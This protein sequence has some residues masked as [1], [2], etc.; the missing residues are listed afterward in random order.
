M[1]EG[2]LDYNVYVHPAKFVALKQIDCVVCKLLGLYD[3]PTSYSFVASLSVI[4]EQFL[5][6]VQSELAVPTQGEQ[7][8]PPFPQ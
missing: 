4:L 7:T 8:L 6:R 5:L 3:L 2:P 1:L